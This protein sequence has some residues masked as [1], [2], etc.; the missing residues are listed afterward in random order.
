[1]TTEIKMALRILADFSLAPGGSIM[2][3]KDVGAN[4]ALVSVLHLMGSLF[5]M[6][7]FEGWI[8]QGFY[9]LPFIY[10]CKRRLCVL[11]LNVV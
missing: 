3:L 6:L 4:V 5:F 9:H 2:V 8:S 7:L 11:F 10:L 1:M